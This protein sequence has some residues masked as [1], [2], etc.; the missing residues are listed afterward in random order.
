MRNHIAQDDVPAS[1]TVLRIGTGIVHG[2]SLEHA[3][4]D[5]SLIGSQILRLCIEISLCRCLDAI[6]IRTKVNGIRIHRNN[7]LLVEDSLQFCTN[8]PFLAL[9][10]DDAQSGDLA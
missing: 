8:D 6:G 1:H 7:L 9:H 5:S 2:S 4:Q 10:D 3:H